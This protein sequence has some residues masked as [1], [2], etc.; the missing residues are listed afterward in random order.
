MSKKKQYKTAVR[1]TNDKTGKIY[2]AGSTIS[3]GDFPAVIIKHWQELG[4][5][6]LLKTP[7]G[8]NGR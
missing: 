8:E 4:R 1:L 7:A 3:T 2:P 5:I 6:V